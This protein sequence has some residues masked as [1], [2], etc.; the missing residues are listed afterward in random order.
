VAG[1]L[2]LPGCSASSGVLSLSRLN[3]AL[4]ERGARP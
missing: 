2:E 3:Q 1:A 4:M